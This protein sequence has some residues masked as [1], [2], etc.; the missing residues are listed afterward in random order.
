MRKPTVVIEVS[1]GVVQAVYT[2]AEVDV[3]LVD[4]DNIR[5]GDSAGGHPTHRM[6]DMPDETAAACAARNGDLN[7]RRT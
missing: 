4:W 6:A 5:E 1:G 2:D 3:V 7:K